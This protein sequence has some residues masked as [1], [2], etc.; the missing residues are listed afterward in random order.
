MA[1]RGSF[2]DF[3][4]QDDADR[5]SGQHL[6]TKRR[7][8]EFECPT[9]SAHNPHETFGNADEVVCNWCGVSFVAAVDDEGKLRLRE[10]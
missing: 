10:S 8:D 9:C 7:F 5:K 6:G 4:E 1:Q 3:E 2:N